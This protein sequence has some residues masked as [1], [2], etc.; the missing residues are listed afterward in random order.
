[1][2]SEPVVPVGSTAQWVSR[3]VAHPESQSN[4][5]FDLI[6]TSC[7]ALLYFHSSGSAMEA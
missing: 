4:S 5:L 2:V 6:S 1:M 3:L 7:L